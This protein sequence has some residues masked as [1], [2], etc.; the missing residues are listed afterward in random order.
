MKTM[1]TTSRVQLITVLGAMLFFTSFANAQVIISDDNSA[2]GNSSAVLDIISG[3]GDKGLLIPRVNIPSLLAAAPVS[4]PATGLLVY[5]TNGTTGPGFFYWNGSVWAALSGSIAS[6]SD[7][8]FTA[9][10]KDYDD[11]TNK[12]TIPTVPTN[13]SSFINDVGY[14]TTYSE[15]DPIFTAWDKDYDDLINKPS[16]LNSQWTTTGSDIYYNSG[17]VGIGT[18][19]PAYSLDISANNGRVRVLGTTGYVATDYQNTAGSFYVGRESSAGG[20]SVNGST[21]YAG[22]I[23][24]QGDYPLQLATNNTVCA[25]ITGTG[26]VGIGTT[27]PYSKLEVHDKIIAGTETSTN[28]T[29]ILEGR[30]VQSSD[31]VVNSLGSMYSSGAWFMGYGMRP[32][33]GSYG[34]VSSADNSTWERTGIEL[35]NSFFKLHYAPA[36]STT[37]GNDI[38][39]LTTPFFVDLVN[40][41]VGIGTTSPG[42]KLEVNG[43]IK[44]SQYKVD[45]TGYFQTQLIDGSSTDVVIG[46]DPNDFFF[47]ERESNFYQ[48]NIAGAAKLRIQANGYVGIGTESPD[49]PLHVNGSVVINA[50]ARYFNGGTGLITNTTNFNMS[51]HASNDIVANGSFVATSDKRVKEN[52]TDIQNSLDLLNKLRPVTYNK[53]DKVE[54]GNR[55]NYGFIAQEV[56][57]VM[58]EAVNTGKGE[59]PVLKPF[60][61]VNFE[62]GVTYTILVKNGDNI[63]EQTYTKGDKRPTGEIIV[64]SKTVEDFKSLTYDMIF[65]VAVDAI[66][67]QQAQIEELKNQVE[68]LSKIVNDLKK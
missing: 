22:I 12:P 50:G 53:I 55:V 13:V 38:T 10:D 8:V 46:C 3:S 9:W 66:Q 37:V 42:A 41:R 57:E 20:S 30:Y 34:Y 7:P 31:D 15:N 44:A 43:N 24:V 40:G 48:F 62:D 27:T 54:Q 26:N 23:A 29:T 1:K 5:N 32:K 2:S 36:Q 16:I 19:S 11:L 17:N 6:E 39:G 56:E 25:T 14:L 64:K 67:E 65:T 51:I 45:E 58:P 63:E 4:S 35:S 47:Y 60:E 33:S 68:E 21:A 28:G 59:V 49:A 52:I 61:Q 18:T